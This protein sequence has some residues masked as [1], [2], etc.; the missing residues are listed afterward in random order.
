[1]KEP[2]VLRPL[3]GSGRWSL[4]SALPDSLLYMGM[5]LEGPAA[6]LPEVQLAL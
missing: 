5:S 3:L 1:M 6:S 4:A 2:S